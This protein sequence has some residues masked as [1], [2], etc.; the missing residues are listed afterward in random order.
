MIKRTVFNPSK[1]I[2]SSI[3]KNSIPNK[4]NTTTTTEVF[5][6][7]CGNSLYTYNKFCLLQN[8]KKIML[9]KLD[10]SKK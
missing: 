4:R 2:I 10:F 1:K 6:Y 8:G 5:D 9:Q 3:Q 7:F